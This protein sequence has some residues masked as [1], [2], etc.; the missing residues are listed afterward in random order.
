MLGLL[1]ALGGLVAALGLPTASPAW[2]A[3]GGEVARLLRV[4]GRSVLAAAPDSAVVRLGV[5][6]RDQTAEQALRRAADAVQAVLQAAGS[7]GVLER[8]VKTRSLELVPVFRRTEQE[9]S[10]QPVGYEA[11]YEL[12]ILVYPLDRVGPLVDE[13]VRAGANRVH[14]I[15]FGLRDPQLVQQQVLRQA[16]ADAL[17]Q[18]RTVAEA[19]GVRLGPVVSVDQVQ[20]AGPG[21]LSEP[22]ALAAGRESGLPI[23]PGELTFEASVQVTFELR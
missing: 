4:T 9:G 21:G 22:V 6:V 10:P 7:V 13:A 20:L 11:R 23:V 5:I 14:S 3:E 18:A 17:R 8:N 12:E 2:A 1:L 16:V 15:R 19:A